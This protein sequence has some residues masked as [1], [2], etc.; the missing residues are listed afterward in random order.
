MGTH[1]DFMPVTGDSQL[2]IFVAIWLVGDTLIDF[3]LKTG[4]TLS[5]VT[6]E[7]TMHPWNPLLESSV[8]PPAFCKFDP[9]WLTST[10]F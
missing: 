10:N 7:I 1:S 3:S 6:A 8:G 5:K 4:E 9:R 2:A